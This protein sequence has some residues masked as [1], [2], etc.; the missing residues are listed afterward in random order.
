VTTRKRKKSPRCIYIEGV[1]QCTRVGYGDPP[2][3]RAHELVVEQ[4]EYDELDVIDDI[5]ERI[6]DGVERFADRIRSFFDQ[7]QV[8]VPPMPIRPVGRRPQPPPNGRR[9]PPPPPRQPQKQPPPTQIEA[10]QV[11]G[12]SPE[13]K[14]TRELIKERKRALAVIFHP[15]K[16]GGSVEAMRRVNAAADSLLKGLG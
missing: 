8:P 16:A 13:L 4:E 1:R 7:R 11:L 12:F 14:L 15:D 6:N 5:A 10:R 2:L 3:C 9:P